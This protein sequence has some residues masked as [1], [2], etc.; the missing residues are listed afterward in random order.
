MWVRASE[1]VQR[2]P[3]PAVPKR[4]YGPRTIH[5]TTTTTTCWLGS[6]K[7]ED[8]GQPQCFIAEDYG[9]TAAF[10]LCGC[11]CL[12]CALLQSNQFCQI[13][14]NCQQMKLNGK[15]SEPPQPK[16]ANSPVVLPTSEDRLN[17]S[18][19]LFISGSSAFAF[20]LLA[21]LSDFDMV[22]I[23]LDAAKPPLMVGAL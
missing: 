9:I 5:P 14:G 10:K 1:G 22:R 19:P 8:Q 4:Q 11:S 13:V 23:E 15:S 12:D 3:F 16:T 18:L 6:G 20:C 17:D 2:L 21:E 7:I